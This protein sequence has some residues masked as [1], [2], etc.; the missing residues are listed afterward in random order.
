[1]QNTPEPSNTQNST[2]FGASK[3][4]DA[5]AYNIATDDTYGRTTPS[6]VETQQPNRPSLP[7]DPFAQERVLT[8]APLF[9]PKH[10]PSVNKENSSQQKQPTDTSPKAYRE[11]V[12]E[13]PRVV[14]DKWAKKP[15]VDY[16]GGDWGDDDDWS[17]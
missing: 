15:V 13:R 6:R 12:T 10:S 1:M 2:K 7:Q 9:S 4:T 5:P 3:Q 8:P 14:E 11:P 16:S 17:Y